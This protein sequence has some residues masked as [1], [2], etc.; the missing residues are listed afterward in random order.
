MIKQ[1]LSTSIGKKQMVAVTGLG[2]VGFLLAH[3]SGN[4]LI[5]KGAKA[6]NDYS[7][8][9]HSLGSLLWV[10]RIGLI[11]FFFCILHLQ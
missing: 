6:Y 11:A 4:F 5:Y 7:D 9:L 8:F 1:Y 10:A 2:M 3:L